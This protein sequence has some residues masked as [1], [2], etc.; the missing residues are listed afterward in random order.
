MRIKIVMDR[1]PLSEEYLR[2]TKERFEK[3][4]QMKTFITKY[5]NQDF[6]H[7]KEIVSF[8]TIEYITPFWLIIPILVLGIILVFGWHSWFIIPL[9]FSL[10]CAYIWSPFMV[11]SLF[12]AGLRKK[13]F[14][15]RIKAR[16]GW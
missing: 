8:V 6:F 12:K 4:G 7:L 13:G 5:E 1:E 16:I 11:I 15:G 9:V 3:L 10:L 2:E 14:K